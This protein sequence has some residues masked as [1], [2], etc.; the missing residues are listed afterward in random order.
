MNYA[1]TAASVQ[2]QIKKAGQSM[3]LTRITAGVYDPSTGSVANTGTTYTGHGVTLNYSQAM[4]DGTN[5]LQGDQRVYL[6]PLIGVTPQAGDT[7]TVG[8]DIYNVVASKPLAPA[9]VVVLHDCQARA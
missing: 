5:I 2:R 6:D 4:I 8:S 3:T 9:G 1:K 7:L